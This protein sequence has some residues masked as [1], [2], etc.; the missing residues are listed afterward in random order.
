MIAPAIKHLTGHKMCTIAHVP[1]GALYFTALVS[2][3]YHL[4]GGSLLKHLQD[5]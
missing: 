1:R 2:F 4:P 5:D 3:R